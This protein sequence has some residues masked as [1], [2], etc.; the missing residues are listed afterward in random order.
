MEDSGGRTEGL[1]WRIG[2]LVGIYRSEESRSVV[3]N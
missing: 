1:G 3:E 2:V